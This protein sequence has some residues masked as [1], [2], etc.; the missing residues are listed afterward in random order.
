M[1][2]VEGDVPS[3]SRSVPSSRWLCEA[4]RWPWRDGLL[5]TAASL[6]GRRERRELLRQRCDVGGGRRAPCAA[7]GVCKRSP[8]NVGGRAVVWEGH[9]LRSPAC[10]RPRIA[11]AP[12]PTKW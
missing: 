2:V 1:R 11:L 6:D 7:V 9:T 4:S 5:S 10:L 3:W 8:G 12:R